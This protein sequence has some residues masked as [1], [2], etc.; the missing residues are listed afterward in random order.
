LDAEL[1]ERDAALVWEMA[2]TGERWEAERKTISALLARAHAIDSS[3]R[4]FHGTAQSYQA[5]SRNTLVALQP[6]RM[7]VLEAAAKILEGVRV[8]QQAGVIERQMREASERG[9][10]PYSPPPARDEPKRS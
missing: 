3:L 4:P 8:R 10:E 5:G 7:P 9:D 2:D 6:H 1:Q